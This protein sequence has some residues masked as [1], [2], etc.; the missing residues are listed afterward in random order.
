MSIRPLVFVAMPFGRKESPDRTTV[1][2]FD[3]VYSNAIR[4]ATEEAGLDVIR[5]DEE[6]IGGIIHAPMFERLLLAEIAIVDLTFA[7]A[8]VF[9]ELGIRHAARPR[10][11]ILLFANQ[12]KLPFDVSLLRAIP[13]RLENGV[14]EAQNAEQMKDILTDYLR[15]AVEDSDTTDSPLFQ[16]I[17]EFPGINLPHEVTESFRD[18]ARF[19]GG[20]R[21]EIRSAVRLDN[22]AESR[23]KL[24]QIEQRLKP[25]NRVH[26]ELVID[27]LLAYRE[28]SAWHDMV[29]LVSEM[30]VGLQRN[31]TVRQ[32]L[33]LALNRRNE[34][35]DRREAA[36]ILAEM[37]EQNGADPETNGILGRVYRDMA[38][39]AK[40]NGDDLEAEAF[41][42]LAIETYRDGFMADPRDYYPGVN[43]A[44]LLFIKGDE[45]SLSELQRLLPVLSFAVARRGGLA[46][47]DP[48]VVATVLDLAAIGGDWT[49]AARAAGRLLTLAENA[50]GLETTARSLRELSSCY[51]ERNRSDD[52]EQ[53]D[54]LAGELEKRAL[55]FAGQ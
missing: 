8:N 13:Y 2:D 47:G 39:D 52:A 55:S 18:R 32:Q 3:S 44:R 22:H 45:Q 24:Q 17:P 10:S 30:P 11:T 29:R 15:E 49:T 36:N 4:P 34:A 1:I 31:I 53:A 19:I 20:I 40:A 51:R 25:F 16:L 50:W 42:D 5:A 33:A 27:L 9:Y 35:G 41:A 21:D 14:L 54:R 43:A 12:S 7:N 6:R 48:W 23:S 26:D 28:V 37:I 38:A 46:S